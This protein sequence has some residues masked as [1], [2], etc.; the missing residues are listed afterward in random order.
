MRYRQAPQIVFEELGY[1]QTRKEDQADRKEANTINLSVRKT[2]INYYLYLIDMEFIIHNIQFEIE[3]PFDFDKLE[4]SEKPVA[5]YPNHYLGKVIGKMRNQLSL[6]R[7][8]RGCEEHVPNCVM[9]N[10]DG[11]ALIRIHKTEKITLYDLPESTGNE[12][13]ECVEKNE[14]SFPMSFVI[15][16]YRDGKCQVAIEKSK[17]WDGRTETIK[18][19]L[20]NCFNRSELLKS[21]GIQVNIKEKTIATKFEEFID[22][23]IIDHED[24][25]ETVTFEFPYPKVRIFYK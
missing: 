16:D 23:R 21:L 11:I 6:N 20:Q 1:N 18:N 12:L 2:D 9:R 7:T 17:N 10:D 3:R 19:S 25:I 5:K 15:V 14:N 13:G 22:Q 8:K 24:R 4:D